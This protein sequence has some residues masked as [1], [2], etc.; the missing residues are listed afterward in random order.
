M[1]LNLLAERLA[2]FELF[3]TPQP[4]RRKAA[5]SE[6]EWLKDGDDL[7]PNGEERS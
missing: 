3:G 6:V 5:S 4:S 1:I 2:Q 7:T